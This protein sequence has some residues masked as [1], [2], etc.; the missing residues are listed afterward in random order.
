MKKL[1]L[2]VL[3]LTLAFGAFAQGGFGIVGGLT[4]SNANL[5]QFD[6]KSLSLYHVGIAAK[7]PIVAGF[8]IQPELLYQ[9]KG[10][11]YTEGSA[12]VAQAAKQNI[13]VGYIELPVQV[14]WGLDLGVA[15]PYLFVE[16]FVGVGINFDADFEAAKNN[17]FTN[18]DLKRI[19][20]GV[21]GGVGVDLFRF[22]QVSAKYYKN[23]GSLFDAN[24]NTT[25]GSWKELENAF[26]QKSFGGVMVSVGIF[27]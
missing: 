20:Y 9:V 21:G 11:S 24:G 1:I 18:A 12:A 3:A 14:Q 17:N 22:L 19:E 25:F 26:N 23:L 13:K 2:S 10:V 8:L 5:Q 6:P 4:S 7:I 27:F 15:R 16:P